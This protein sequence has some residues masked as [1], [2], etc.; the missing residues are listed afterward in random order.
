MGLGP[1]L[2]VILMLG[3]GLASCVVVPYAAMGIPRID[4][5]TSLHP[6]AQGLGSIH[7]D[8]ARVAGVGLLVLLSFFTLALGMHEE[9]QR[10]EGRRGS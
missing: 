3:G 9:G 5:P 7:P 4:P 1:Y 8:V 10:R 6:M 2:D